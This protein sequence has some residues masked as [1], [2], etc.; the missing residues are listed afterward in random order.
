MALPPRLL[1]SHCH[2]KIRSYCS[3][4]ISLSATG[5]HITRL[6]GHH[7]KMHGEWPWKQLTQSHCINARKGARC[8]MT[9]IFCLLLWCWLSFPPGY[10]GNSRVSDNGGLYVI[11]SPPLFRGLGIMFLHEFF[12]YFDIEQSQLWIRL[13]IMRPEIPLDVSSWQVIFRITW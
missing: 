11:C 13:T 10:I 8:N 3:L 12:Q 4:R 7:W 5:V 1:I 6:L 2:G 9:D